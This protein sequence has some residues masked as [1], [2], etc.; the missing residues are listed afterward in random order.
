MLLNRLAGNTLPCAW[1]PDSMQDCLPLEVRLAPDGDAITSP[2]G[3][4]AALVEQCD[5]E[6]DMAVVSRVTGFGLGASVCPRNA[7]YGLV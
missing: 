7:D 4:L 3:L 1:R 6:A 2:E 5:A